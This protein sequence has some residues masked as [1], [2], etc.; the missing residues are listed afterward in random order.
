VV[1]LI[2]GSSVLAAWLRRALRVRYRRR[3]RERTRHNRGSIMQ[4]IVIRAPGNEDVMR[5]GEVPDP[6]AGDADVRI[7]VRATAVNR[8]DLLQRRG[9]YPPP[10]GASPILGLECAGEVLDVG[11]AVPAGRFRPGDRVMA[12]LP[13]GGYAQQAVVHHGSVMPVP[14]ALDLLEA[15]GLPEVY[16]TASLNLFSLGGLARGGSALVHGGGSGVGTAVR[17]S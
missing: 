12:L 7:R 6:V 3:G 14:P 9:M 4:A 11:P 17:S 1:I 5:L 10:P 8:A 13:G 16:L 15:G 2:I